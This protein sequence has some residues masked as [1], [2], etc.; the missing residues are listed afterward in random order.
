M[1][2]LVCESLTVGGMDTES[3][4]RKR[5]GRGLEDRPP[6]RGLAQFPALSSGRVGVRP[7]GA[8]A[9]GSNSAGTRRKEDW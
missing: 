8:W 6:G 7:A 1:R 9:G 2:V 3:E 5:G 4:R